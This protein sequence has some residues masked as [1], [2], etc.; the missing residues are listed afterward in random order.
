MELMLPPP[1]LFRRRPAVTSTA[2]RD[3][4]IGC[5]LLVLPWFRLVALRIFFSGSFFSPTRP[6][7]HARLPFRGNS[8]SQRNVELSARVRNNNELTRLTTSFCVW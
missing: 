5:R 1:A 7:H 8:V 6:R 3:L 4:L 2:R